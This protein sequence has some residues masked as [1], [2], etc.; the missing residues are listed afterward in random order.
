MKASGDKTWPAFRQNATARFPSQLALPHFQQFD[1]LDAAAWGWI[2]H[3]KH[4]IA[5]VWRTKQ[6]VFRRKSWRMRAT[7]L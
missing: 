1:Y 3:Q 5:Q 4:I 2:A 6:G 7:I